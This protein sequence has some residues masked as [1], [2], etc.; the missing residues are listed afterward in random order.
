MKRIVFSGFL[1]AAL[2]ALAGCTLFY[3]NNDETPEPGPQNSLSPSASPTPTDSVEPEVS[4]SPSPSA[5]T[6]KAD[7][8][9]QVLISDTSEGFLEVIAEITNFAEDGGQCKLISYSGSASKVVGT[10]NAE[11]NVG[12]TQCFPLMIEFSDLP[13]GKSFVAVGYESTSYYGE[14]DR[15]EVNIP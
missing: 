9:I 1:V 12:R 4:P 3:P 13:K 6:A 5:S 2:V 14:S 15:F 11:S 7:A 8:K 10:S